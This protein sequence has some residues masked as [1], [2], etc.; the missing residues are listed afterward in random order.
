MLVSASAFGEG[1]SNAIGEAMAT[2][3]PVVATDVGDA[4]RIA[5]EG[6]IIVP[7]RDPAALAAAIVRLR[8]DPAAR[9][10][11]GAAARRRIV[12]QFSLQHSL[13]AFQVLYRGPAPGRDG[14]LPAAA[15]PQRGAE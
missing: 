13:D 9:Q 4:K 1:F 6:G 11:M 12:R 15:L 7:P 2:G 3:I 14:V 8:D 10:A 5:G